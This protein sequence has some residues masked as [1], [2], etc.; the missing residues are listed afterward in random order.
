MLQRYRQ[1]TENPLFSGFILLFLAGFITLMATQW[2]FSTG[3]TIAAAQQVR[4]ETADLKLLLSETETRQ[5]GFMLSGNEA[6]LVPFEASR[7][8]VFIA[9][10]KLDQTVSGDPHQAARVRELRKAIESRL[11]DLMAITRYAR[12]GEHTQ[13]MALLRGQ[14]GQSSMDD[15]RRILDAMQAVEIEH[16]T[17]LQATLELTGWLM[18]IGLI[19]SLMLA[20]F[21]AAQ[22]QRRSESQLRDM[23]QANAD[24]EDAY[25]SLQRETE[26]RMVTEQALRQA[27]K[28]E[29]LG[30]LTGG[31]SH[32]FNNMLAIVIGSLDMLSRRMGPDAEPRLTRLIDNAMSG[33]NRAADLTQR[34]LSFARKQPLEPQSLDAGQLV[35]GMFELLRRTLGEMVELKTTLAPTLWRTRADPGQLE[36]AIVNLAINARDAMPGGGLLTIAVDNCLIDPTDDTNVPS[37]SYVRLRVT[38]TGMGMSSD[39]ITRAFDPFFTTKGVGKGTGL[40]LSQVYGFVTQSGGHIE[41]ASQPGSGTTIAI[42]LPR[43]TEISSQTEDAAV[44][45]VEADLP[46]SAGNEVLLVVEDEEQVRLMSCEALR[47]LGYT[48]LSAANGAEALRL[49]AHQPQLDMLFTDIVMP[50]MTGSQL[51]QKMRQARPGLR[52]LYVTG[53]AADSTAL[54]DPAGASVAFLTKPFTHSQ[55]AQKVRQVLDSPLP[56]LDDSATS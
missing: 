5:R 33:A 34:L 17:Q 38:D 45:T 32:D 2:R 30:S 19:A 15:A 9:Y 11:A 1:M 6:D 53:Y 49:A 43:D 50:G 10:N 25:A 47:E 51:A 35:Q 37:G 39:I 55:L 46:H 20:A 44:S 22:T 31:I 41:I 14:G 26:S 36:N 21:M 28:M 3:S 12:L 29:A 52:V 27:Q 54:D 23:A 42:H 18:R 4:H 7:R 16:I 24:L 40:G 13:A 48:V 56:E 8:Q